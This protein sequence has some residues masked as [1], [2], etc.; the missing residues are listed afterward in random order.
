MSLRT[1]FLDSAEFN[2]YYNCSS[3][4]V[5]SIPL[6]QRA[7]PYRGLLLIMLGSVLE[8]CYVPCIY[9]MLCRRQRAQHCYR[10]MLFLGICEMISLSTD[11]IMV[12]MWTLEGSVYCSQPFAIYWICTLGEFLWQIQAVLL[13]SLAINRCLTIYDQYLADRLF[14]GSRIAVWMMFPILYSSCIVWF[15]PPLIYNS[16]MT[17][18]FLNPHLNYLPDNDYYY[19]PPLF[20]IHNISTV[21]IVVMVYLVFAILFFQKLKTIDAS[22][23]F[24]KH[25]KKEF[26][27]FIQ[28]LIT[29]SLLVVSIGGY[30]LE[31][32]FNDQEWIV[33][34]GT[35]GFVLFQGSSAL[36]YLLLNRTIRTEVLQLIASKKISHNSNSG[37]RPQTISQYQQN[38]IPRSRRPT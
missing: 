17:G 31:Q 21:T 12:G 2:L 13:I 14:K 37:P 22:R 19:K 33:L 35:Y 8:I 1:Y 5:N 26:N 23:G 30:L 20:T 16:M 4:D 6:K 9:A 3:Y 18:L 7:H 27:T 38:P 10:L 32:H 36:V 28:V 24:L 11:A 15:A 34:M 25:A 29:C